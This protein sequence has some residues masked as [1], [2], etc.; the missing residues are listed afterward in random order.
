[1]GLWRPSRRGLIKGAGASLLLPPSAKA[2]PSRG[3][4]NLP[5]S[6]VAQRVG[7]FIHFNSATYLNV[8]QAPANSSTN[9]FNPST[10]STAQWATSAAKMNTKYAILTTKHVNGFCLWPTATTAYSIVSASPWYANSGNLDIV[11]SF[12]TSMRAAGINPCFYFSSYDNTFVT[13]NPS[14][15]QPQYLA[16]VQGQL[17]ELL[18]NYGP[19]GCIWFDAFELGDFYPWADFTAMQAFVHGLQPNCLCLLNTSGGGLTNSQVVTFVGPNNVGQI[20]GNNNPAEY[21]ECIQNDGNYFW[22]TSTPSAVMQ[23][24]AYLLSAYTTS[25]SN[26][27]SFLLDCPPDT[28]GNVPS[29]ILASM[30]AFGNLI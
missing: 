1:M 21:T 19:I 23:T 5:L 16:M 8:E 10:I 27:C 25:L 29:N 26:K 12:V 20:V 17:T 2:W 9:I 22:S 28:T 15:T 13:N 18:T 4:F 3:A 24:P 6:Y 11:L 14:Y 30:T 7:M